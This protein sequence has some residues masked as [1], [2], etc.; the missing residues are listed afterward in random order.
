V[1]A[2]PDSRVV[3]ILEAAVADKEHSNEVNGGSLREAGLW[4]RSTCTVG[5][6]LQD[7]GEARILISKKRRQELHLD[8]DSWH[9]LSQRAEDDR[10]A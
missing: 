1:S 3:V 10:L 6:F 8:C 9:A 7:W 2:V 4:R 5:R